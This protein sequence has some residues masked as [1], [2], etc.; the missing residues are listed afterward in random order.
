M[1]D[2]PLIPGVLTHIETI[3][4]GA[5][6]ELGDLNSMHKALFAL[7]CQVQTAMRDPA[8]RSA[9]FHLL[10]AIGEEP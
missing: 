1:S 7:E 10:L 6:R 2:E 5:R 4:P 9:Y 3:T 8:N